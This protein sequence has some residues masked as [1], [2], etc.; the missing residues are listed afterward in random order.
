MQ[1]TKEPEMP[2][3]QMIQ[4]APPGFNVSREAWSKTPIVMR[5]EILRAHGEMGEAIP[6]ARDRAARRRS[7][8]MG[9][10]F[11][12]HCCERDGNLARVAE[13]REMLAHEV[14]P[15]QRDAELAEFH[16]LAA[17]RGTT[18]KNA[19]GRYINMENLLRANPIEGIKAVA[20][21]AGIDLESWA[22]DV[23]EE[24]VA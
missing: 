12:L 17:S 6:I 23:L 22:R 8:S 18:V 15:Q 19:L 11:E 5:D 13:L 20:K 7:R 9:G 10:W 1:M 21:N 16:A 3:I 14:D 4:P 24:E 2:V